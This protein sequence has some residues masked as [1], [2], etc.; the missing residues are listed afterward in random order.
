M[1]LFFENGTTE[2]TI[3]GRFIPGSLL[4]F[5]HQRPLQAVSY[6]ADRTRWLAKGVACDSWGA[7]FGPTEPARCIG[8][9]VY[10]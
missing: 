5:P 8:F 2:K 6:A 3:H 9:L 4:K 10:G 7:Q 1:P